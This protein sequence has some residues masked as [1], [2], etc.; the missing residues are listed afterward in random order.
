MG[1]GGLGKIYILEKVS[2]NTVNISLQNTKL[3][4]FGVPISTVVGEG[5]SFD[6]STRLERAKVGQ[7]IELSEKEIAE[8]HRIQ[9]ALEVVEELTACVR[10]EK[11]EQ[12]PPATPVKV[13][14]PNEPASD[15][16]IRVAMRAVLDV[17][18]SVWDKDKSNGELKKPQG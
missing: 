12:T 15:E 7:I 5:A 9:T 10:E 2:P 4:K 16:E 6:T 18:H 17:I 3:K 11:K 8:R 14:N 13:P 1:I